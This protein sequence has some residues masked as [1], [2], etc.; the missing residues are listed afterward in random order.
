MQSV[1]EKDHT[2][3]MPPNFW[4]ELGRVVAIFGYLENTLK[5]TIL[6]LPLKNTTKEELEKKI[7][8][9]DTILTGSLGKLIREL[10]EILKNLD[11]HPY[12]NLIEELKKAQDHRNILI[13]G[14]WSK[15]EKGKAYPFF[16]RLGEEPINMTL[17]NT[18]TLHQVREGVVILIRCCIN[19]TDH[20]GNSIRNLAKRRQI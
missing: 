2:E 4:E 19:L 10:E 14:T 13:H 15:G 17:Y 5:L 12:S 18:K 3:F 6:N 1:S 11:N 7:Q 16:L 9:V 8:K 20:Y